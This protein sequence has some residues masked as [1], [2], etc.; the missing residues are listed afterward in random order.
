LWTLPLV[1]PE[2][3]FPVWDGPGGPATV[4]PLFTLYD[5]SFRDG[6]AVSDGGRPAALAA[7]RRAGIAP[8]DEGRL[9]ADPYPS[10][11]AWCRDRVA[12]RSSGSP[13]STGPSCWPAT[14][15]CSATRSPHCATRRSP[16]GAGPRSRPA[17]TR[18]T[19]CSQRS[20]VTCTSHVPRTTTA[21]GSRKYPSAIRA[22]GSAG[23]PLPR[24]RVS[25]SGARGPGVRRGSARSAP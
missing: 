14:G 7:A 3:E 4:A 5:Y 21:S 24:P 19:R 12:G 9:H 6:G 11:A 23:A 20:T 2:D 25:S 17:G 8:A 16:R 18:G 1:T 13:P 10:V 22:S 15:R